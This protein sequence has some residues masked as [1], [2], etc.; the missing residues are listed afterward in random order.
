MEG[1]GPWTLV[2]VRSALAALV[3][4]GALL[5]LKVRPPERRHLRG[6]AVVALGVVLGFPTLT[7]LALRTST[8]AH[9]AVVVGLL[10]LT[11]AVCSALRTGHRPSRRFWLAAVAGAVAV[12][13]FTVVQSGARSP[14][15]TAICSRPCWCAP[16]GTPRA[17]CWP[18]RYRAG[19]SSAGRW[20]C[21]CR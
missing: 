1:F 12:L 16:P 18:G 4:G 21:A 5:A 10:P 6:L 8:T 3:A 11:T 13:T 9:A 17:G 15:P 7:T 14:R 19:R 2:T 20:C